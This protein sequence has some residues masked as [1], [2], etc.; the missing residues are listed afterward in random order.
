MR[1]I[2]QYKVLHSLEQAYI[3]MHG[4]SVHIQAGADPGFSEG[5]CESVVD[6]E[7]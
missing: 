2:A 1:E 4:Y 3:A 6:F 7:G 5:G